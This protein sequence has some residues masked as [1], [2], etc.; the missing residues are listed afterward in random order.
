[1][2]LEIEVSKFQFRTFSHFQYHLKIKRNVS[3]YRTKLHSF[4]PKD[5]VC[6]NN[7]AIG[8]EAMQLS[9]D[10]DK[11]LVYQCFDISL[12]ERSTKNFT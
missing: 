6:K 12:R 8:Q 7:D 10:A 5:A 1:M 11:I 4:Q 3:L 2:Y 9:L